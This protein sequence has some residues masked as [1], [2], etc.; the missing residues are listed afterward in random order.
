[1]LD[2][3]TPIKTSAIAHH[4]RNDVRAEIQASFSGRHSGRDV[5]LVRHE[6]LGSGRRTPGF[7]LNYRPRGRAC[8]TSGGNRIKY[9]ESPI[10]VKV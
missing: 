9:P 2:R 6:W 8:A 1:M 3:P 5:V 7:L 4:R 10:A